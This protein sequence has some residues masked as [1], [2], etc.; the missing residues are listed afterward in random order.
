[1]KPQ[2]MSWINKE[3]KRRTTEP[4]APSPS[5]TSLVPKSD[6][7]KDLW[8]SI[9]DANRALPQELQLR[10]ENSAPGSAAPEDAN[11]KEWLKAPND[12]TLG[13]VNTAIRY[14]WPEKGKKGSN[15]FWIF[16]ND[17]QQRYILQQRTN[18]KIPPA[19]AEYKSKSVSAEKIVKLLVLGKRIKPRSLRNRRFWLF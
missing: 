14:V 8:T 3:I 13:F 16:W 18:A 7:I 2:T 12:A 19:V 15:N 1:M 4:K 9:L 6:R 11:I 17:R 5:Q 10:P